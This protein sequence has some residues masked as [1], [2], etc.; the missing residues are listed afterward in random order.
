[1]RRRVA[2]AADGE[3]A[4]EAVLGHARIAEAGE[5]GFERVGRVVEVGVQDA[6]VAATGVR[7]EARLLVDDEDAC[8]AMAAL[9][10]ARDGEADHAAADDE[11]VGGDHVK[12]TGHC[13]CPCGTRQ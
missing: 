3:V 2:A 10:L 5:A 6:A 12:T 4:L 1:V 7:A 9:E 8:A 11:E 13:G